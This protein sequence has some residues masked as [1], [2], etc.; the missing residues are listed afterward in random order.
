MTTKEEIREWLQ[1]GIGKGY[2]HMIVAC[3]T[4]DHCDFPVYVEKDQDVREVA[5][6]YSN[7]DRCL[8]LM[9]VYSYYL[10]LEAQLNESRVMNY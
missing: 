8:R 10:S 1:K 6:Q 4:F 7:P 3:D 9:E 5:H 2:S